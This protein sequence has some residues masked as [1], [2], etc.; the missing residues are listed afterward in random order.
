MN[1]PEQQT[2]KY[3]DYSDC[4]AF[5]E[6]KYGYKLRDYFGRHKKESYAR[7]TAEACIE[8]GHDPADLQQDLSHALRDTDEYHRVIAVRN[9][10][11][12]LADSRRPPYC[13]FWHWI[14]EGGNVSN[15]SFFSLTE[16]MYEELMDAGFEDQK[17]AVR[18][19]GDFLKEF[20]DEE[21]NIEFYV[22]W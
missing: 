12:A 7:I 14:T 1:K 4:A 20:A 9:A 11:Y 19:L 16:D 18:I 17:W 3:W 6:N 5:I 21:G 10:V 15:G 22:W 2:K 13:D 8:L